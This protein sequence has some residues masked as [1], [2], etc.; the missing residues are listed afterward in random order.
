MLTQ[1]YLKEEK[2]NASLKKFMD[3]NRF[4][5]L[6]KCKYKRDIEKVSILKSQIDTSNLNKKQRIIMS[7][8]VIVLKKLQSIK[9]LLAKN[10][11]LDFS[12]FD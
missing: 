4:S 3:S 10:N 5:V 2:S 9:T 11:L 1:K 6:L 12:V 8:P 7:L